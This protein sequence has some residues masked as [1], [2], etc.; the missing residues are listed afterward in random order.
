MGSKNNGNMI[1]SNKDY[2]YVQ[3]DGACK[4][5][6]PTGIKGYSVDGFKYLAKGDANML[7]AVANAEIGVISVAFGVVDDFFAYRS[8][9]YS[10]TGCNAINHA[11]DVVGYSNEGGK[12]YWK[13]RN[14]W[15]GNWGDK[16]Y[17]KVARGSNMCNIA[18]YGHY[19]LVS[20]ADAGEGGED[21]DNNDGDDE[22]EKKLCKWIMKKD[23]KMKKKIQG[24]DKMN[25]DDAKKACEE[26]K[27]CKA[28]TC[29]NPK[30][31]WLNMKP[32]GR[33]NEKFTGY[34]KKC[35][36]AA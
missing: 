24:L 33:V 18:N 9:V 1:A 20:G 22:E 12:D 17:V 15:G 35:K 29:K 34:V 8:G 30:N 31:C 2:P 28:I 5:D 23:L 13:A 32:K 26:K 21:E 27:E 11:L 7:N 16:G 3:R 19:P 36:S 10:G 25:M 4:T 6:K 14:S